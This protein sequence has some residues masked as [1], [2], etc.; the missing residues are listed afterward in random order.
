MLAVAEEVSKLLGVEDTLLAEQSEG[1]VANVRRFPDLQPKYVTEA[2]SGAGFS[3]GEMD[4]ALGKLG[5]WP[6]REQA[7]RVT[8]TTRT[9]R[10]MNGPPLGRVPRRTGMHLRQ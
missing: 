5:G 1:D 6:S 9:V 10:I 3:G 2:E 7:P 4:G 8:A